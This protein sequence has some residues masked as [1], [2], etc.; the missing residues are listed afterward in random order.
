[1]NTVCYNLH[2]K[3][4]IIVLL[5]L[6]ITACA[7]W[8][9]WTGREGVRTYYQGYVQIEPITM[10]VLLEQLEK[11]GCTENGTS[12]HYVFDKEKNTLNVNLYKEG[13]IPF[14]PGGGFRISDNRLYAGF[15]I[16]G[17]RNSKNFE[18][19]VKEQIQEVGSVIVPIEG[20]WVITK[21]SDT[22]GVVY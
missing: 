18:K 6:L 14:G 21:T 12:C 3:K 8:Y 20:T 1:M 10:E 4:S 16:E 15:D 9:V 19:A 2:M 17:R 5:V 13:L 7:G 11:K 22:T